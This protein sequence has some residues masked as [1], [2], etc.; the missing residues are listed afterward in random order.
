MACIGDSHHG[1]YWSFVSTASPVYKKANDD[2][3]SYFDVECTRGPNYRFMDQPSIS[4]SLTYQSYLRIGWIY[5]GMRVK[6]VLCAVIPMTRKTFFL[7]LSI[8]HI[9]RADFDA[10]QMIIK[11]NDAST[12]ARPQMWGNRDLRI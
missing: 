3:W 12:A 10:A 7:S 1:L 6:R 11:S 4:G 8:D 2:I 5:E 9:A